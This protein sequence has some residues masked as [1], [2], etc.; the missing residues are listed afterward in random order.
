MLAHLQV[1]LNFFKQQI[2][3]IIYLTLRIFVYVDSQKVVL[4]VSFSKSLQIKDKNKV[5]ST[6]EKN[7]TINVFGPTLH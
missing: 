4:T 5:S 6:G 7:V 1:S 2:L 3:C